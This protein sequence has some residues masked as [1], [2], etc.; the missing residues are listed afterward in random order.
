[1]APREK[2]MEARRQASR[3]RPSSAC[4]PISRAPSGA[5]R[6]S[7]RPGSRNSR[8]GWRC[9]TRDSRRSSPRAP[10]PRPPK[11]PRRARRAAACSADA[12]GLLAGVGAL[13]I[14]GIGPI[15]LEEA[16]ASTLAGAGIGAAA[17]GL[18]GAL[19]GIGVPEEDARHFERGFQEGGVLV[20]VDAGTD[21]QRAQAALLARAAPISGQKPTGHIRRAP[22]RRRRTRSTS[23]YARS[24]STSRRTGCRRARSGPARRS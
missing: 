10:A 15:I 12:V 24:S 22:A 9:G 8:S 3:A 14:P 20:T 6:P 13:A 11:A 21:A 2:D 17:G 23:S 16:L 4:T 5:S 1:M 18:I 7:R 19:A